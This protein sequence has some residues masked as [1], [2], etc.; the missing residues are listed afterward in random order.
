MTWRLAL[1]VLIFVSVFT[2][3]VSVTRP[4]DLPTTTT[5]TLPPCIDEW[6]FEIGDECEPVWL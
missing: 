4:D 3:R 1:A 5:T 2:C 6:H